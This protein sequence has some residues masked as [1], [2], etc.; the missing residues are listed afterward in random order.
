MSLA[1]VQ[2]TAD[3][4]E[5]LR[6]GV[7]GSVFAPGDPELPYEIAGFNPAV[8]HRPLAVVAVTGSRDV[9]NA[10]QWAAERGV[11]IDVRSTGHGAGASEGSLIISTRRMHRVTV[12]AQRRVARVEAGARWREVVDAAAAHGLAPLCGS[13]S[14]VGVVGYTLGGGVGLLG[15]EYGFAADHVL[16]IGLVTPDGRLRHITADSEPELF[17]AAR[18]GQGNFGVV[19]ALDIR[20][21]PVK[22]LYAGGLFFPSSA[23]SRVLHAYRTW[24]P[25]LP[26]PASSS[27]A[28]QLRL[29]PLEAVPA[30]LR[31]QSLLHLRFS[32]HGPAREG[33]ALLAP[34]RAVAEPIMGQVG[35]IPFQAVD[36]VHQDSKDPIPSW[37]QGAQLHSLDADTVDTLLDAAAPEAD[38]P[39]LIVELRQLGGALARPAAPPNAVAGRDGAYSVHVVGPMFPGLEK[40]VPAL[41]TGVLNALKPWTTGTALLTFLGETTPEELAANWTPAACA[42]LREVKRTVDP[43]NLFRFGHALGV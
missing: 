8:V 40:T 31:G 19:T 38:L 18:G 41:G 4:L 37:H 20:L 36:T 24:A 16:A 30:H 28:L 5:S 43:R 33:E 11:P 35:E 27:V 23:A 39:P 9:Q 32:H 14:G 17:W 13:S 3:G 2:H 29:P 21:F 25:T 1:S 6:S 7:T 34:M 26:E 15:R 10:V 22:T 42:R 12:D